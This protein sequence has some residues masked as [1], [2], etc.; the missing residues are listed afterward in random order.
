[1]KDH[2]IYFNIRVYVYIGV[3]IHVGKCTN[4]QYEEEAKYVDYNVNG[5]S[6]SKEGFIV[7]AAK[8]ESNTVPL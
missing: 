6:L 1:M 7:L 3:Y 8:G 4:T 5:F 2:Y